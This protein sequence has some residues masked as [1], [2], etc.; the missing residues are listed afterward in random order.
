V[1]VD[2]ADGRPTRVRDAAGLDAAV[3]TSAGPW[4]LSGQWW[5][6]ETWARDE[7]DVALADHTLWRLCHDRLTDTWHLDALYD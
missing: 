5:D 3:L 1:D 2:T 7:W 4:R 6:T